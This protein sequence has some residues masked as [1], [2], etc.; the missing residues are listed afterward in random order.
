MAKR[1]KKLTRTQRTA[2]VN[3]L[4]RDATPQ[5]RKLFRAARKAD[6]AGGE[7][8]QDRQRQAKETGN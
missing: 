7:A 8:L 3:Q 1:K 5:A 6:A 4:L 2:L